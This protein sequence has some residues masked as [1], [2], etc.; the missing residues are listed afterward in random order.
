MCYRWFSRRSEAL[1]SLATISLAFFPILGCSRALPV[2]FAAAHSG[3]TKT[4][5][6]TVIDIQLQAPAFSSDPTFSVTASAHGHASI[7]EMKLYLDGVLSAHSKWGQLST[8]LQAD[9]GDHNLTLRASDAAGH[10]AEKST[11]ITIADPTP[12]G[13][14]LFAR[15]DQPAL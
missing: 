1:L 6:P 8:E 14:V 5:S 7:V 15:L 11:R 12:R 10:A 13:Q 3:A 4:S 9:P 2:A